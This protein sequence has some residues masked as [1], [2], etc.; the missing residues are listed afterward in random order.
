MY[1]EAV[2][3][4]PHPPHRHPI[5]TPRKFTRARSTSRT[6]LPSSPPL[7]KTPSPRQHP[8]FLFLFKLRHF[9]IL[10][11]A[12]LGL[13]L[14][15]NYLVRTYLVVKEIH[16]RINTDTPCPP[17]INLTHQA[18]IGQPLLFF[19]FNQSLNAL[20]TPQFNF[21][22][23]DYQKML[24]HILLITYHFPDPLYQLH[25]NSQSFPISVFGTH[26]F[27]NTAPLDII[28]YYEPIF[29]DL[30]H[31]QLN[32]TIHQKL[33]DLEY[34]SRDHR[35][36]WQ[37][38]LFYDLSE[39]HIVTTNATYIIDLFHLDENLQKLDFITTSNLSIPAS[40]LID[41]RPNSPIIK[42]PT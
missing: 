32:P 7:K 36:T 15:C 37:Q 25:Y 2:M 27:A 24:P 16:C 31:Y 17:E 35:Q 6:R 21:S 5:K 11:F 42:P 14:I 3:P 9:L 13:I 20:K 18:L 19:N 8:F 41:L 34:L 38:L 33:R 29:D 1:N 10:I 30:S 40:S 22:T 28:V 26:T 12:L 39:F 23:A 4:T